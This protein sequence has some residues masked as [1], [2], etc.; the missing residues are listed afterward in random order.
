MKNVKLDRSSICGY[1]MIPDWV[2]PEVKECV[3]QFKGALTENDLL[4]NFRDAIEEEETLLSDNL[5]NAGVVSASAEAFYAGDSFYDPSDKWTAASFKVEIIAEAHST[6]YK[7]HFYC[8]TF[9][10][11]DVR[12]LSYDGGRMYRVI[13]YVLARDTFD[14]DVHAAEYRKRNNPI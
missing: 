7:L 9:G 12:R 8:N 14:E 2:M 13:Q 1:Q 11:V 6:F 3:L 5:Y 10:N 4:R